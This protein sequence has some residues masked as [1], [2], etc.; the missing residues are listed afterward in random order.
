MESHN[1][2]AS[3]YSVAQASENVRTEFYQKTYL[4][5]AGAI[6]AFIILEAMLFAIP[7]ID[8]FV[9]KMIGGGM[10]WLLVLGLFMGASWIANKWATS[11]T[12]RGMQYAGLGL[13]IVA[14]AIIFLP[15][16][17][18]A[19]RFTGQS[20]LVG[21]AAI[22]TLGLF[23]G[24]T[25]VAFTSKKDFSFLGGVLK[26]GSFVAIGLIVA[27]LLMGFNLGIWFSGAMVLIAGISILYQTSNIIH[28]Y[29]PDQHVAASL[30]LF[31]SVALLFWYVL[32]ILVSLS[33]ND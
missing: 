21:Q 16:L 22:I 29:R 3:P 30:G 13:Y 14:E 18:I 25:F 23:A 27:S 17:L 11:D 5:L 24:L 26:I 15:L 2:Y 19:V 32:Q 7:G 9:F 31:A 10:S 12:S 1:P 6:G 33:S 28:N 4:H 8:L 20:H